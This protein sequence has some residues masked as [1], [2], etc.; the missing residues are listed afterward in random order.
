MKY[1]RSRFGM[2][3]THCLWGTLSSISS[4]SC[5]PNFIFRLVSV[6]LSASSSILSLVLLQAVIKLENIIKARAIAKKLL[7]L[8]LIPT[9][10]V[11]I[12]LIIPGTAFQCKSPLL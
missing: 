6:R 12:G 3:N 11:K 5:S 9:N 4:W 1:G 7:Y 8:N 2:L 10:P